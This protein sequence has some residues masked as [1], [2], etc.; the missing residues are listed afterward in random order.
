M[1]TRFLAHVDDEARLVPHDPARLKRRV[2]QDVWIS[3]HEEPTVGLRSDQANKY[4]WAV[5][6][7]AI[8][9]ETGNDPETVHRV[10]KH[11]AVEAG[12][13]EPIYETLGPDIFAATGD[14]TTKVDPD[15]FS[16]YVDW[17]KH[18]AEHGRFGQPFHIP[19]PGE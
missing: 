8:C 14:P 9:D 2:G 17:I 12:I 16:R 1:S 4:L 7:R 3:V 19:E 11:M 5:V 18:E 13:L 6:Y 15:T 10:L